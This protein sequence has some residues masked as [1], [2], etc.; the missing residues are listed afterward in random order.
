MKKTVMV[1]NARQMPIHNKIK[2]GFYIPSFIFYAIFA[3]ISNNRNQT[4]I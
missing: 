4:I 1:E 3:V 2:Y